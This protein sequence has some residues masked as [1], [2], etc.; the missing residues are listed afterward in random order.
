VIRSTSQPM[1]L[2]AAGM[3]LLAA[4]TPPYT[5]DPNAA[6]WIIERV[7]LYHRPTRSL[8]IFCRDADMHACGWF[9]NP[10][11][12]RCR[13]LSLSFCDGDGNPLEHD[14]RIARTWAELLFGDEVRYLWIESPYSESGKERQVYH[15][16]VMC[17][18]SWAPIIPRGEPYSKEFTEKGW[19]SWSDQQ[20]ERKQ[21]MEGTP[22]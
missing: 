7:R 19:K 20:A 2:V 22:P 12:D 14:H 8:L 4:S 9:K 17:D 6:G 18:E 15:Y 21:P 10:D 13:H 11:W 1:P 16:R 3:R 5:G